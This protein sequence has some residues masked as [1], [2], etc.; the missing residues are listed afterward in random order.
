MVSGQASYD[1]IPLSGLNAHPWPSIFSDEL[2]KMSLLCGGASRLITGILQCCFSHFTSM[3][4]KQGLKLHSTV[5]AAVC[6][7]L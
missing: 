3:G 2:T 1:L 7:L 5:S 4:L 6:G